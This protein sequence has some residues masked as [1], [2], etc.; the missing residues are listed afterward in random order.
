LVLLT[1]GYILERMND[2][3]VLMNGSVPLS[4]F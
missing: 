2:F 3:H 1:G 4:Y